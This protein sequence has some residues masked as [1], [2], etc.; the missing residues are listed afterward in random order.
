MLTIV[1][2]PSASIGTAGNSEPSR[3][4][5]R[6]LPKAP[7]TVSQILERQEEPPIDAIYPSGSDQSSKGKEDLK[8]TAPDDGSNKTT[9]ESTLHNSTLSPTN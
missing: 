7:A 9:L 5:R 2:V 4:L 8:P 3:F 6:R 1:T